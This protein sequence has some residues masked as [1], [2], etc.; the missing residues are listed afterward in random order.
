M[1]RE[2]ASLWRSLGLSLLCFVL[3]VLSFG[4][5][6]ETIDL[7]RAIR[8][9]KLAVKVTGSGIEQVDGTVT[10]PEGSPPMKLGI[11]VGMLFVA[12]SG[13]VQNMVTINPTIVDLTQSRTAQFSVAVACSNMELAIPGVNDQFTVA[14]APKQRE[15]QTLLPV[16]HQA[17]VAFDTTQAAVWIVTDNADYEELGTLESS[18]GGRVINELEAAQAMM[19]IEQAKLDLKKRAI[20][21]DRVRICEKVLA[22]SG[23]SD[24]EVK[25][26]CTQ[27]LRDAGRLKQ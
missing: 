3:T 23:A 27:V 5:A 11:P 12:G 17:G 25:S 18:F 2:N 24:S 21:G 8:D 20:W 4:Q 7:Y 16:I 10:R 19:F 26:W 9:H 13:G 22:N 14:P 15:L 6:T 1:K